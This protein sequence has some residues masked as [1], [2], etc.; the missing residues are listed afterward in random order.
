MGRSVPLVGIA[1]AITLAATVMLVLATI[2]YLK[3]R[4]EHRLIQIRHT[5]IVQAIV[6]TAQGLAVDDVPSAVAVRFGAK[7]VRA[8]PLMM[9]S[10]P[11][12][13]ELTF[14]LDGVRHSTTYTPRLPVAKPRRVGEGQ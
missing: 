4:D 1:I 11:P 14:I 9:V 13:V 6:E 3:L 2:E 10:D 7:D 12:K 5:A 8:V